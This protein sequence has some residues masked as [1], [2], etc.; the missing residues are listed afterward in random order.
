MK[1]G[2]EIY[3]HGYIDEIRGD[4]VIIRN[5]GGYFGTT[6]EEVKSKEEFDDCYH[7]IFDLNKYTLVVSEDKASLFKKDVSRITAEIGPFY[8]RHKG[9]NE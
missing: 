1:I 2:D 4:T 8:S 5:E 7:V 3:I 9:R 6:K